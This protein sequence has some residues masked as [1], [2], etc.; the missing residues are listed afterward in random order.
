MTDY[1]APARARHAI[2]LD[3][4]KSKFAFSDIPTEPSHARDRLPLPLRVRSFGRHLWALPED[5]RR[6]AH[7]GFP[8]A[9]AGGMRGGRDI[10]RRQ[11]ALPE[12]RYVLVSHSLRLPA[13]PS[14]THYHLHISVAMSNVLA[15]TAATHIPP[16]TC[17]TTLL[18]YE[19]CLFTA[20]HAPCL[21]AIY[22]YACIKA[23]MK[24]TT[25]P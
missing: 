11:R 7:A 5:G 24:T 12:L 25:Q 17:Y 6:N 8:R 9:W 19:T 1:F 20:C 3:I 22:A 14:S 21:H 13:R 15:H 23:W 4:V 18:H 16:H 2:M 10:T